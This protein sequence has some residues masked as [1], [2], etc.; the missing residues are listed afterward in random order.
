M[1][2]F[3]DEPT[4]VIVDPPVVDPPLA[5]EGKDIVIAQL[6]ADVERLTSELGAADSRIRGLNHNINAM[7]KDDVSARK[8]REQ[9]VHEIVTAL[10]RI[11]QV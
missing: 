11:T 7:T 8:E 10:R 4:L 1:R 3:F 5:D 2:D 6:N 9:L